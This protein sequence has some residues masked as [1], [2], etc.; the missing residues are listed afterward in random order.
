MQYPET[1]YK[2][3][4][5]SGPN[6]GKL[7][8]KD[9]LLIGFF[10]YPETTLETE[11]LYEN[12]FRAIAFSYVLEMVLI[13]EVGELDSLDDRP[14]ISI[15]ENTGICSE[16]YKGFDYPKEAIYIVGNGKYQY[17]SDTFDTYA[18]LYIDIPCREYE[19]L[20]GVQAAAIVMQQRYE[21]WT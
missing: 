1:M 20:Y 16:D 14:I 2:C 13:H 3:P 8:A 19:A 12:L 10:P 5:Y 9:N 18:N 21:T 17:P 6:T 4:G 15:E 11:Y 7:E